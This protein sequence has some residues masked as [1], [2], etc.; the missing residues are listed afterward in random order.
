LG[1]SSLNKTTATRVALP[2]KLTTADA[3]A[4]ALPRNVVHVTGEI[5]VSR[6]ACSTLIGQNSSDENEGEWETVGRHATKT[7][8]NVNKTSRPLSAAK[9]HA[10]YTTAVTQQ[11]P[12]GCAFRRRYHE[13]RAGATSHSSTARRAS[14]PTR[15]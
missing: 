10:H 7:A 5:L 12:Y 1:R 3:I 13:S 14:R 11:N 9:A 6:R 4:P 2:A 8:S 15:T